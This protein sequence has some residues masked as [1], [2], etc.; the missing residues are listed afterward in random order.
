MAINNLNRRAFPPTFERSFSK[1]IKCS[2]FQQKESFI[3]TVLLF[4]TVEQDSLVTE[5][6]GEAVKNKHMKYITTN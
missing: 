2:L 3:L 6:S 4:F 5:F 1:N